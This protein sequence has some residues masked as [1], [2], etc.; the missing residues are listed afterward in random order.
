MV[1]FQDKVPAQPGFSARR[2]A[3]LAVFLPRAAGAR[4]ACDIFLKYSIVFQ[5]LI[6]SDALELVH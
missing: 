1:A 5:C 6:C 3:L 2:G 4:S